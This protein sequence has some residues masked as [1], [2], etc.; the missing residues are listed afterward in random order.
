MTPKSAQSERALEARSRAGV[1]ACLLPRR[2]T[3]TLPEVQRLARHLEA[4]GEPSVPLR[5]G[6]LHTYTSD[7]LDPY[8]KFEALLQGLQ[9]IIYHG[10]YGAILQEAEPAS[11][12][13]EHKPDLTLLL[14]RWE[15]VDPRLTGSLHALTFAELETLAQGVRTHLNE[16]LGVLRQAVGG[17]LLVTLLP[18]FHEPGLGWYEVNASTSEQAWRSRVKSEIASD[19]RAHLPST[20]LLDLEESMIAVGRDRFF[21]MR[22]W[23]TARFPFSSAATQ[24][25][26]RRVIAVGTVL[27]RPRAKVIALDADNTLWGGILGEDGMDGIALGPD[28]PGNVYLAFQRRLLDYQQRGFVLA[29]C[30]KNNE[31][32]VLE[33]LRRHPHQILREEHFA[34]VRVNWDPKPQNLQSLADELNL[35]LD[36]VVF[37]DDSAHE[38]LMVHQS[39]PDVEVVQVP[40]RLLDI[41]ACLDRVAR[42]EIVTRTDEDQKKTEM[43]VRERW[44]RDLAATTTDIPAYLRSLQMQMSVVIDGAQHTERIAQLTQKT[45]Q[46]NLT[47]RRYTQD[48]IARLVRAD[49]ELVAHFSLRDI[50]GDSGIVGVAI[51]RFPSREV[52]V[53]DTFLMSCRVIGRRAETAFLETVLGVLRQRGARTSL[54]E[55]VPTAKNKLVAT[56]LAEHGYAAR[57]DGR[58]ERALDGPPPACADDVPIT[59]H[60]ANEALAQTTGRV[61]DIPTRLA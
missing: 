15:D 35:G 47:T 41:P 7:L 14:L 32:E 13:V 18:A 22:W 26:V 60:L 36:A 43:Y 25:I 31:P 29:L 49:D 54:A 20:A 40:A 37:V 27:K 17:H 5:I 28:Y 16:Y 55:Y 3:L 51:V 58:Y 23:Y 59:V 33:V 11:G 57:A 6:I 30:S 38:C 2:P 12:L 19:L 24:E 50:F 42:L 21:D 61:R 34:A 9:P 48:E 1:L 46:F 4:L 53:L 39:L 52:A 45:N 56:F 10:P 8:L 44:R